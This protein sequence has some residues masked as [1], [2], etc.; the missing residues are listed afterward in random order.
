[1]PMYLNATNADIPSQQM[2]APNIA[3]R[4][5]FYNK[6]FKFPHYAFKGTGVIQVLFCT[7]DC[8]RQPLY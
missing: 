7:Y 6:V 4:S 2:I 5:L 1:M 8:Y 3:L